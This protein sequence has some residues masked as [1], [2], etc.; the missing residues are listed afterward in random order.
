MSDQITLTIDGRS[1]SVDKDQTVLQAAMQAGIYVPY[2]C[3]FPGMKPYGACR[4]CVVD[5]EV[6]GR[7]GVQASCTTPVAQDMV[8]NTRSESVIEL[9]RGILDL[10]MAEHPHG[11]LTCHRIELCGPQDICQRHV[12]VTDR[13]TIC[14]KNERCELKDTVRALELDLTTPLNYHRRDLPIHTDDPF[15]DRDYNLCIV[16]VR[17]VRVC[18]EVRFDNALSLVSRSGVALVGTSHGTSLLESGCEFC[19]ACIDACPTGALVERD[20]KWEK[21]AKEVKTICTNCSVGCQMVMEVNRFDKVVR[22]RGDMAGAANRGQ[23]CFKGKFGYDYPNHKSRIKYPM[24]RVNGDLIRVTWEQ[25]LTTIAER[26]ES[27]PKEGRAV[28]ASP[29]GTNEDAYVAQKMARVALGTNS[30][31]SALNRVPELNMGLYTAFGYPGATNPIWDLEKARCVI[32]VSG[33]PTEEQNVLAVPLKKA[34]RNGAQI[35]VIDTRETE[36]TRYANVWLRHKPG[37]EVVL[38]GGMARVILDEAMEDKDFVQNHCD[39]LKKLKQAL[40]TFDLARVSSECGV[41]PD[42]VRRA[43]RAYCQGPA[44]IVFGVDTVLQS[45]RSDLVNTVVNLAL[46]TGNIGKEGGGVFPLLEG[47]NTQGANDVGAAP[48]LLP[49]YVDVRDPSARERFG[50]K[51]SSNLPDLPG[52]GVDELV[53]GIKSGKMQTAILMADG[54]PTDVQGNGNWPDKL[55]SLDFLVVSS[56]FHSSLTGI[57]DVVLPASTYPEQSGTVTNLERRIQLINS[58]WTPKHEEKPGWW[59]LAAIAQRM[60]AKGFE[61]ETA[62]EVFEEIRRIVPAY[63][64]ITYERLHETGIQL[65]CPDDE[66]AGTPRLPAEDAVERPFS[67][68]VQALRAPIPD[69]NAEHPFLLAS[70]RVLHQPDRETEVVRSGDMNYLKRP[71]NVEIHPEDAKELSIEEGDT[72]EILGGEGGEHSVGIATLTFPHRGILG[73][74]TL[75]ADL[76]SGMQ[77]SDEIDPAPNVERLPLLR[78]RLSKVVVEQAVADTV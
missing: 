71:L 44:A 74:T 22:M 32:I 24:I 60:G 55:G 37:T 54:I 33:T 16:C 58:A 38:L 39:G 42:S 52:V 5:T 15:Y 20:Y 3:Y 13:C 4:A 9:R 1:L 72:V 73:V 78:D 26:I 50:E 70:G 36:L 2:L 76:A 6:G 41:D 17:C 51:W 45:E 61:Y 46:L 7:S 18:S 53:T 34:A 75:F 56:A 11:C 28:I 49:G 48:D 40:W 29:R 63:S 31:D 43:A 64:G 35:V 67:L 68:V 57:A 47:A 62:E 66:H 23:A 8:V 27:T 19:G 14:P 77:D 10:L 30:I 25:A 69:H 65:P 21:A 12:G 59:T